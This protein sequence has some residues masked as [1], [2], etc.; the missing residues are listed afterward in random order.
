MLFNTINYISLCFNELTWNMKVSVG[1][2]RSPHWLNLHDIF[3]S[4]PPPQKSLHLSSRTLRC[5]SLRPSQSQRTSPPCRS[6]P[7]SPGNLHR[8]RW[9]LR[10]PW[11]PSSAT[12]C[13]ASPRWPQTISWRPFWRARWLIR[14]QHQTRAHRAWW[15]SCRPSWWTSNLTRPWTH[16]TC[17]SVT[18]PH[19][20]PR[21]TWAC[22]TQAWTIW[23]GWTSP[24]H[25]VLLGRSHHW[26]SQQTSWIH[27]TC[28]CT[29]TD[30]GMDERKRKIESRELA[31]QLGQEWEMDG[32]MKRRRKGL[33]A[34]KRSSF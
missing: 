28:S 19:P 25:Q 1:L 23:S 3:L 26:G 18:P 5:L 10:P 32:W 34:T 27:M 29:G 9:P 6:A 14:R 15:R 31:E 21:S 22:L 11:A 4:R 12:A 13:P 30:G 2:Q 8:S 17:H 24:C 20:P 33:T 16:Q 7:L